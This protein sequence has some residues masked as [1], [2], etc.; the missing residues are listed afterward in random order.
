MGGGP[1]DH[2]SH[3]TVLAGVNQENYGLEEIP[4]VQTAACDQKQPLI[5]PQTQLTAAKGQHRILGRAG[6]ASTAVT[7]CESRVARGRGV[8]R[9]SGTLMCCGHGERGGKGERPTAHQA[10]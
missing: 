7:N 10:Q 3:G 4:V 2:Q 1:V 8:T 9:P 5:E 6:P